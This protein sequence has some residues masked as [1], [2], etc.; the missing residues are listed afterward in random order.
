MKQPQRTIAL[1]ALFLFVMLA[2][3][4]AFA[5]AAPNAAHAQTNE[6]DPAPAAP[7]ITAQALGETTIHL[8]WNAVQ[9][10]ARYELWAWDNVNEWRQLGGDNLTAASYSHTGLTS[11]TTYYY[12]VR[13][14]N[15]DG[16]V[17]AWSVRVDKT[18]GAAPES[19]VLTATAG[20]L[21]NTIS[22]PAVTR[23]T[24]YELWVWDV[25]WTQLLTAGSAITDTV[26]T[27]TGLTG[28]T[29]YYYQGRAVSASGVKSVWS[30]QVSATVMATPQVTAT[31]MAT[32]QVPAPTSFSASRGNTEI[33][34]SWG[35][36]ATTPGLTIASYE[37]RHAAANAALP[38]VWT[39]VGHVL[40]TTVTGL[41]NGTTYSFELRARSATDAA[42]TAATASGTPS[43]VPGA[44]T[45]TAT[46]GYQRIILTWTAPA[47]DGGAPVTAYRIERVNDDGLWISQTSL[48]GSVLS[49]TATGLG[50]SVERVYRIFAVNAAG[51]SDWTSASAT[52]LVNPVRAPSPPTGV[53]ATAGHGK[54]ELVWGEPAFNGGAAVTHFS[55]AYKETRGGSYPERNRWADTGTD[56]KAEITGLTPGVEYTFAVQAHNSAGMSDYAESESVEILPTGPVAAPTLRIL[57]GDDGEPDP[58]P[59]ITL[60]WNVVPPA[61]NGGAPISGYEVEYKTSDQT[62]WTTWDNAVAGFDGPTEDGSGQSYSAAH[63]NQQL[64]LAPGT[65]Y[66]YRVRAFND[67]DSATDANSPGE[68]PDDANADA[69]Q[70]EENGPWSN[71]AVVRTHA[72]A[73]GVPTL[74]PIAGQTTPPLAA[75]T[76]AETAITVR[77]TAPSS[78]GSPIT[79]YQLRVTTNDDANARF[80]SSD[81]EDAVIANLPGTRTEYTHT[82]LKPLTG[83]YY[84]IRALNDADGDGIPGE[85]PADAKTPDSNI[86]EVSAWSASSAEATTADTAPGAPDRPATP[87]ISVSGS[88]VTFSWSTPPNQGISPI[89]RYDVQYQ[90]DDANDDNDWSD[91]TT[92]VPVPPTNTSFVHQNVA[93]GSRYEYRVRAVNAAGESDFT[94]EIE[95]SV[96]ARAPEAP[97]LT[98]SA[99]G[100]A[101][102]LLEWNKPEGNGTEYTGYV[103]QQW[104]PDATP[105]AWDTNTDLLEGDADTVNT[106]ALNVGGLDAGATYY[107]R[108]RTSGGAN[109]GEWSATARDDGASAATSAGAA[110]A[111]PGLLAMPGSDVGSIT[112][113]ITPTIGTASH[114]LQRWY[115]GSWRVIAAPASDAAS[116]T[117]SGLNAGDKYYYALRATNTH[118]TGPWSAVVGAIATA[119]SPDAPAL[120]VTDTDETSVSLAWNVPAD[121]GAAITGYELQVWDRASNQWA[122]ISGFDKTS[123]VTQYIHTGLTAGVTYAYRI[124][125]LPQN[126]DTDDPAN[127][128]G[129]EGWSA[130]DEAD[131]AALPVGSVSATTDADVPGAPALH[132]ITTVTASSITITWDPLAVA[133]RGGSAITRYE[134]HKWTGA[135]W[136]HQADVAAVAGREADPRTDQSDYAYTD[137]G[138]A[139][140][141]KRYYIVRAVNS[142]G[143]GKWSNFESGIT[144]PAAPDAPALTAAA[145]DTSSIQLTWTEAVLNGTGGFDAN[146]GGYVLQRWHGSAF[147]TIQVDSD[148]DGTPDTPLSLDATTTLYVDTGLESGTQYWYR[149]RVDAQTNS[150]F[151]GIATATTIAAPPERPVVSA[152]P[153]DISHNAVKLTWD[154]PDDNGSAIISYELQRWDTS[155]PANQW[156]RLA[157]IS[158]TRTEYTHRNLDPET[159]YVYRVRAQNRAPNTDGFGPWSTV[160]SV[161]TSAAP[162]N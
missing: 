116:Y 71:T 162:H 141:A 86:L 37:Y 94:A 148:G 10:A 135:S 41:I 9:D 3:F 13:A 105:A 40:S 26:Y 122:A 85:D 70:V 24:G 123:A 98:A 44:P 107:F 117:D 118:G 73:P 64:V 115:D 18:A 82:G 95:A 58:N 138:L 11:G 101:E 142:Q 103:I 99:V 152:Q 153:G 158:A 19:P 125:A 25:A 29:T 149:I 112:L 113:T 151:S 75:W 108:I 28:G 129:D 84:S 39:N 60:T 4:G 156:T 124:R 30:A 80:G 46:A 5:F 144:S 65:T 54:I 59:Q 31:V 17:G 8:S 114:E 72:V 7:T 76:L 91:A 102:I 157:L 97:T 146:S 69:G 140:G 161:T 137:T 32:P 36:P 66:E 159:R 87:V 20:N 133:D 68:S 104:D 1:S 42:G 106:T 89:T 21:Q 120:R 55:Y 145:R 43:T 50:N 62:D 160:I 15:E 51:D 47:S 92:V 111:A 154:E 83:Y 35:V 131:G 67:A 6:P 78:G 57:L 56:L 33:T 127:G 126:I 27:H 79:S 121:N 45:L 38:A 2:A 90:R 100:A 81:T 63:G 110:P 61:S 139:A 96:A 109:D 52:T 34:L 23:A 134:V 136:A 155:G 132:D 150:V 119:G 93:G 14:V 88:T 128:T 130:E 143:A 147:T 49:W 16:E 48:P 74:N 77:W 12:Q 53:R 22:W